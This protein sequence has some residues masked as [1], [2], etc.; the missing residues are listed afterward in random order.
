LYTK[1]PTQPGAEPIKFVPYESELDG[2]EI[3]GTSTGYGTGG[4]LTKVA[5]ARLA[6]AAGTGVILTAT[7]NA[8]DLDAVEH[9][10]TWFEPKA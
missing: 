3:E 1:P 6:T 7:K 4:A 10:H 2:V 8:A 5:A 9:L